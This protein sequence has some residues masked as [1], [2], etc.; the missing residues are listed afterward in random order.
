MKFSPI[1]F[2]FILLCLGLLSLGILD[3][4]GVFKFTHYVEF[5]NVSKYLDFPA[6]FIIFGGLFANAFI[7]S[8][9]GTVKEVVKMFGKVASQ[10]KITEKTLLKDINTMMIWVEE[11]RRNRV[12]FINKIQQESKDEFVKYIFTLMSTNYSV[13]DL[14]DIVETQ[15]RY[16]ASESK[17]LADLLKNMGSSGPAFGMFGTLFGL[18]Y[19]LSSLDNPSAVGPGL[20]LGLLATLY[21]VS[22]AHLIFFPLGKKVVFLSEIQRKR[23]EMILE[24]ASMIIAE[25]SALYIKDKLL[26]NLN[27]RHIN[28][29]DIPDE[30]EE[31]LVIDSTEDQEGDTITEATADEKEST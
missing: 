8:S 17:K 14:N 22:T 24:C 23:D 15:I 18:V 19:M 20:A 10:S 11:Y 7:I 9:P 29:P 21:G 16:R 28:N 1:S 25:K 13:N 26:S 5:L 31:E 3:V 12:D 27:L 2:L 4:I 30:S 6:I